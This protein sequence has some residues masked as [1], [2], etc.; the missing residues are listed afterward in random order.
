M[1][2]REF[3]EQTLDVRRAFPLFWRAIRLRC[4]NCGGR[5]I[6]ASW[7]TLRE[8]CP[9]CGIPLNRA[10][11]DYFIGAYLFNLIAVELIVAV[12]ITV[13]GWLTYPRTPWTLLEITTVVLLVGGAFFC[14]PFAKTTWI[15]FDIMLRPVT[16][17][18]MSWYREGGSS[19]GR[20]LPQL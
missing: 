8:R 7:L 6:F 15:A 13:F 3:D 14:Y 5:G 2:A 11:D 20:D 19:T 18:E 4:P 16:P 17:E 9:T 10:E 12:T 1:R